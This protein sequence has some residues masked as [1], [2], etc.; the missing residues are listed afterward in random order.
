MYLRDG[1]PY[2]YTRED[3]DSWIDMIRK[4]RKDHVFAIEVDGEAAGGIGLHPLSDVYRFNVEM[5]YWLS[6][7]HWGKGIITEAIGLVVHD[8]F[9]RHQWVR[10]FAGVFS[11]NPASMRVLE[12][13]GFKKEAIHRSAVKK[14][15]LFMDE[16]IYALLKEEW[17]NNQ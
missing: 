4:N 9:T 13:N 17:K 3:A 8:A 5:G 2:P 1:F 6:E 11:N 7:M 15:T 14:G 12:K 10:I 16:I